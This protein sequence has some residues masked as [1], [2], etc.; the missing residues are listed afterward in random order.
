M[1]RIVRSLLLL[2]FVAGGFVSTAVAQEETSPK[3]S[4]MQRGAD[5]LL[6]DLEFV[7]KLTDP[8]EQKQWPI[9]KDYLDIFL[10]GIDREKPIR[11][12][13]ILGNKVERYVSSFPV[14]NIKTFRK[15]NLDAIGIESRKMRQ[16]RQL[17]KTSG[18]VFEGFFRHLHDYA[19]FAEKIS[20]IPA[21]M[22]DP[23]QG[24]APLVAGK[25]DLAFDGRNQ[26]PGQAERRKWFQKNGKEY[27][28]LFKKKK[29]ETADDFEIRKMF[30]DF[31]LDESERVYV[32]ASH[33]KLGWITDPVAK[34]AR[35]EI[36]MAPLAYT[37]FERA[38][39]L[40]GQQPSYFA[41]VSKSKQPILSGRLNH[42]LDEVR[43]KSFLAMAA[44]LR[45]R[46]KKHADAA[47][48]TSEEKTNR[49]KAFDLFFDMLVEGIKKGTLDCFV[50]GHQNQP[51]KHVMAGGIQV[52]DGED[53]LKILELLP[54]AG[55]GQVVELNV[56]QQGD[57]KIHKVVVSKQNYPHIVGFFGSENLYIG[58]AKETVWFAWGEGALDVL[59]AAVIAVGMQNTGK[60]D[61]PFVDIQ[62]QVG[63]WL[64]LYPMRHPNQGNV[65]R[66]KLALAAFA[67][68]EDTMTLRLKRVENQ[69]KGKLT[70]YQGILRF[71][72]KALANFSKENLDES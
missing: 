50:E 24:I 31:L 27:L 71:V 30:A 28:A 53:I 11:I 19:T 66:R 55:N 36:L 43:K 23:R 72:G 54:K 65:V 44:T 7:M 59:K 51:G 22:P 70:L 62:V 58:S 26:A 38:V 41:N 64:E 63:P 16:K 29:K 35:V 67:L 57:V 8:G 2:L 45:N 14:T 42:P 56:D 48:L 34:N 17:Y 20:D 21:N 33:L 4:I 37:S 47:D 15:K 52:V 12:D 6:R 25:Y 60:P 40:L 32:E 5:K 49:K 10:P 68:G 46:V 9:M 18:M 39:K 61:D 3:V 69:V 13:V 1:I